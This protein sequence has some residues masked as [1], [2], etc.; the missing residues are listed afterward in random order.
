MFDYY[1]NKLVF[2]VIYSLKILFFA[3]KGKFNFFI[4]KIQKYFEIKY[5][6]LNTLNR[7]C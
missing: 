2:I 5:K 4:L 6:L 7:I 1:I 3:S